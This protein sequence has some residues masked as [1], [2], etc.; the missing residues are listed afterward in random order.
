MDEQDCHRQSIPGASE[1]LRVRRDDLVWIVSLTE[2]KSQDAKYSP[3]F[4]RLKEALQC[5]DQ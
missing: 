1:Y 4:L 2:R 3:K 5:P